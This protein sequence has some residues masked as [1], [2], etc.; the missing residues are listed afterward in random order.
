MIAIWRDIIWHYEGNP[1]KQMQAF[2]ELEE[3][4]R[5]AVMQPP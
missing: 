5:E 4:V 2:R 3:T 1:E